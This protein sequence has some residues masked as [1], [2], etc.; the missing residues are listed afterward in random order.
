MN[1]RHLLQTGISL[2]NQLKNS[3]SGDLVG[4]DIGTYRLKL[5]QINKDNP[6]FIQHLAI[7][8][9]PFG[10]ISHGEIKQHSSFRLTLKKMFQQQAIQ[11][12]IIAIAIPHILT[13]VKNFFVDSRLSPDEI[14][15]RTWLEA[16]SLFPDLVGNIYLDYVALG[17]SAE[18]PSRQEIMIIACRKDQVNPYIFLLKEEGLDGVVVDV[19]CYVLQRALLK[20]PKNHAPDEKIALLNLDMHLITLIVTKNEALTYVHEQNYKGH[21][22]L[23]DIKAYL[24]S[25]QTPDAALDTLSLSQDQ[26]YFEIMQKDLGPYLHHTMQFFSFTNE[27]ADVKQIYL[28]G[29]LAIIPEIDKLIEQ[30][31]NIKTVVANPFENMEF[32]KNIDEQ[33]ARKMAPIFMLSY[34]LALS[35]VN[36][37]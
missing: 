18:T 1:L 36:T 37:R 7:A 11:S 32:A 25:K 9:L 29:D 15:S 19:D 17:P 24:A 27:S 5:I 12:K 21:N 22:L 8:D 35:K 20:M 23:E 33:Q 26:T 10:S 30:L 2:L 14:E 28:S 34:G 6:N 31:I 16:N 13:I 4:L 3:Y